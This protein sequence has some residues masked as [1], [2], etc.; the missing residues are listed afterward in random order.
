VTRS[1]DDPGF[2]CDHEDGRSRATDAGSDPPTE[3]EAGAGDDSPVDAASPEIVCVGNALVDRTYLL[4]NFPGP[5]GGAF[6][7]DRTERA[8][9]VETNVA[10][11]VAALGHAAGV[12][13]RLG[14][15]DDADVVETHLAEL[16]IDAR[17]VRR[18]AGDETSYCLV[19]A[20]EDG[21]R[22]IVGGGES[23]LELSLDDA[24]LAY[25]RG[26]DVAFTSAYAPAGVLA[27]LAGLA[28][29]PDGPA[30]AFDLAAGFDDL[31]RRGLTRTDVDDALPALDLFVAGVDAVRSYVRDDDA[32]PAALAD[33]L[34]ER[35]CAR[36]AL[37]HGAAGALLFDADGTYDVPA[38]DVD[39]VDTTGAG[40]A[41]TAGLIHAWLLE[42]RPPREAGSFATGAAALN[43]TVRGA[44]DD[45]PDVAAVEALLDDDAGADGVPGE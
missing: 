40:D 45:P 24:D 20:T 41:F 23:T 1:D 22:T 32:S 14:D 28:R 18:R 5:D 30:L 16:P 11:A 8:G 25:C 3:T 44:H 35:G 29:A 34:R 37:T 27:A 15:D 21:R 36:G 42:G 6:V 10:V 17:R 13:S 31:A 2:A 12:I 38:V 19:L 7:L 39:V 43:C 4:S 26:A 33:A 9:G